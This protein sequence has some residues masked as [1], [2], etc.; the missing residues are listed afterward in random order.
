[1]CAVHRQLDRDGQTDRQMKQTQGPQRL[2]FGTNQ[3]K[4]FNKALEV[5][6]CNTTLGKK[7]HNSHNFQCTNSTKWV[8]QSRQ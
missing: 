5:P 6:N 8:L 7:S 2:A 1:M 3:I 4:T